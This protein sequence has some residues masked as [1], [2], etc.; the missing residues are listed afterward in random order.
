MTRENAA[1]HHDE[2]LVKAKIIVRNALFW[3]TKGACQLERRTVLTFCL[4]YVGTLRLASMSF[5]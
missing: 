1:E 5:H 2:D 4:D 3:D